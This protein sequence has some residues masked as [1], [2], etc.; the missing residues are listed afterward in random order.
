MSRTLYTSDKKALFAL[1]ADGLST[2]AEAAWQAHDASARSAD[3]EAI[4]TLLPV[5]EQLE[6]L[7]ALCR[8]ILALHR[9]GKAGAS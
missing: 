6:T 2:A 9:I 5:I 4:G 8:T 3:N 1:L 7:T